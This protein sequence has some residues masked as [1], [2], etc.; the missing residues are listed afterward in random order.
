MTNAL[1]ITMNPKHIISTDRLWELP[2]VGSKQPTVLRQQLFL[3]TAFEVVSLEDFARPVR[4]LRFPTVMDASS[5][6]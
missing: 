5:T 6:R 2:A 4:P 3:P 1:T